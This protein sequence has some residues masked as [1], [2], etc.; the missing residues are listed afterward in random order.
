MGNDKMIYLVKNNKHMAND[1]ISIKFIELIFDFSIYNLL[2]L[3]QTN[4][5]FIIIQIY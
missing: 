4:I 3:S 1:M 5:V 2:Y